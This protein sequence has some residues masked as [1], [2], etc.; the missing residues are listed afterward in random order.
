MTQERGNNDLDSSELR[1]FS[2]TVAEID[3]LLVILVLL[4]HVFQD[5]SEDNT[6]AVYL[7]LIAFSAAIIAFH[8]LNLVRN[9]GRGLL[10][11]ETWIMILFIT[12]VLYFTG[13]L[14]SPLLNLYLL[15]IVTSALTLGQMVTLLQVG[16]IGACY[17]FLGYVTDDTF[18]SSVS[19]GNFAANIA[20]MLL[21]AYITTMLSQDILNAMA[22]IRL[23]SETDELTGI[24]NVRA[25]NAI[26]E[27][28][29][30]LAVRYHRTF[31]LMMIDSD[32]LKKMNDT[33]G[34]EAGDRL[35]RHVVKCVKTD[36][37]ATDV[38]ARCGGDE[39][40]CLLPETGGAGAA[41]VGEKVRQRIAETPLKV[42]S[43]AIPTS[44]SI[45]I[46]THPE[47]GGRIDALTKNADRALY[48]SKA[49]GRN[50]V[51]VFA[52]G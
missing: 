38:I 30:A 16:L 26:A 36:L 13:R 44:V 15:P 25:F 52:P 23:I 41:H 49:Q 21:V 29:C 8:Y 2:R 22:K 37:R 35:I 24:Y 17:L 43:A 32:N 51:T 6:V 4:Y 28:E 1:D 39:F 46:A 12:W 14:D 40:V 18:F 34:H 45:G 3:W 27:R 11:I 9:P 33:H 48:A 31:S 10:A 20:P 7:G 47:H 50:R 42:A 19:A 5:R